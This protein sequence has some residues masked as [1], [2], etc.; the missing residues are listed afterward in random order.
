VNKAVPAT[1]DWVSIILDVTAISG[2]GASAAFRLQWSVDGATWAE[3]GDVF[4]PITAPGTVV[5]RFPT[6]A[7][8]WRAVC[9]LSGTS[10]SFTGSA[11]C[12]S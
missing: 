4:D 7:P 1:A 10:P 8:Y 6:K 5:K 12:Y 3:A 11:N 2:A 9:N